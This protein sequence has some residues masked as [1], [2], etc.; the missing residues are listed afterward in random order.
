MTQD[1]QCC[2]QFVFR[3]PQVKNWCHGLSSVIKIIRLV[4]THFNGTCTTR[5]HH[6]D[7]DLYIRCFRNSVKQFCIEEPMSFALDPL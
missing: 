6:E 7:F 5:C 2:I 3:N 1:T 4:F